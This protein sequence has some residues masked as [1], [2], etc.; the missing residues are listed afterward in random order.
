M[1][2]AS[3]FDAACV[4]LGSDGMVPLAIVGSSTFNG[5]ASTPHQTWAFRRAD[6]TAFVESPFRCGNGSRATMASIATLPP[7]TMGLDRLVAIARRLLSQLLPLLAKWPPSVEMGLSVAL[8]P[9]LDARSPLATTLAVLPGA[10]PERFGADTLRLARERIFRALRE[11]LR[12]LPLTWREAAECRAHAGF[13]HALLAANV[14]LQQRELEAVLVGGLDTYHDPLV[15]EGLLEDER[16]FDGENLDSMI[17]GEGGAFLMLMRRDTAAAL[18]LPVLGEI[19]AVAVSSEPST[20]WNDLPCLGTGLTAAAWAATE[21]LRRSGRPLGWWISDLTNEQH[22]LHEL[23][24]AWPRVAAGLMPPESTL[25]YLPPHFGDLGAATLPTAIALA[26]EGLNRRAP[27]AQHALCTASSP[28]GERGCV[29]VEA[30]LA[31]GV[32]APRRDFAQD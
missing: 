17:P 19:R 15:F 25:D 1:S 30:G 28:E 10:T 20:P 23:E 16:V 6:Q 26:V 18:R 22:R 11:P 32:P 2:T 9:W 8:P 27:A 21:R 4:N 5:L 14:A 13:A 3:S 7:T 12:A 31:Q 29:L 24:L